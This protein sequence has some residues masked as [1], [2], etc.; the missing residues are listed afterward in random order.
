M[1]DKNKGKMFYAT[2]EILNGFFWQYCQEPYLE[3]I[4]RSIVEFF[5][6]NT[7]QVLAVNFFRKKSPSKN[8]QL[9]SKNA[10]VACKEKEKENISFDF[11]WCPN[12]I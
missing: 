2:E 5:W 4:Q 1:H 10:F 8:V 7:W 3:P 9:C 11:I 6:K 12:F